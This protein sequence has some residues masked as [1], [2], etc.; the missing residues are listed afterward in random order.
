MDKKSLVW[1]LNKASETMI[2][3]RVFAAVAEDWDDGK[4]AIL[5][6][7]YP[8]MDITEALLETA[9][10]TTSLDHFKI[11]IARAAQ[12]V[13]T[14]YML[15][16]PKVSRS[17]ESKPVVAYWEKMII[18]LDRIGKSGLTPCVMTFAT[19]YSDEYL[20]EEMLKRVAT[21]N[22]TEEM[23]VHA[24]RHQRGREIFHLLFRYGGKVTDKL[25]DEAAFSGTREVWQVL[26][27]QG[28][29]SSVSVERLKIA[30]LRWDGDAVMSI[31]L[32]HTDYAT[33]A[34]E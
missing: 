12:P 19:G 4:L 21:S 10:K 31:I 15:V 32:D 5:L 29:E 17:E 27:A 9:V 25:L 8:N 3:D 30:A 13:I 26:L 28:Y 24:A 18:L 22:I 14:K 6:D 7:K 33:F 11:L 23:M 16:T 34:N 2:T 20:L 1:L